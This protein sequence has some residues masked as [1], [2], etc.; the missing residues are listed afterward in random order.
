MKVTVS[1][2]GK[3]ILMGDHAVVHG[4]P[5]M[6]SAINKRLRVHIEDAQ[7]FDLVGDAADSYVEAIVSLICREFHLDENPPV[8]ISIQ[9]DIPMGYHLGTS[10][11]VAVAT[12]GALIY[13]IKKLW[14]PQAINQLA[15]EAEKLKHGTPS[16]V[17]NTTVTMGG[18]VWYRKELEFLKSIWQLPFHPH[19][20]IAPF[21]L[22]DTGKPA[23]DTGMMVAYVKNRLQMH[24]QKM[25]RIFDTNEQQTKRVATALKDGDQGMLIDAIQQGEKTLEQM[26]VVSLYAKRF[27][28][29][30]E[31]L[32]GA[33]K[34]LGG[35]GRTH[36]VGYL[37]CY[38]PTPQTLV[39]F[40]AKVK[41]EIFPIVLG[42]EGI[43]LEEK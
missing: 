28:R 36:G 30:I 18:F 43:R 4:K 2:P 10:A 21:Y 38:H 39:S 27:I 29:E 14:N 24:P 17:D 31:Q 34:I 42:E 11:A 16:G 35:G 1:V 26:G 25:R 41:R 23:E 15:Y 37:L 7:K 5:A 3:V 33:A 9:S 20:D 12:I 13:Y 6:V 8:R 40:G 19:A 22:L 32:G